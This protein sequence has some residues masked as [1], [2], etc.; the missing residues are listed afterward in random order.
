MGKVLPAAVKS[1][2]LPELVV[3]PVTVVPLAEAAMVPVNTKSAVPRLVAAVPKF[4]IKVEPSA[5][6]PL[7]S[8]YNTVSFEAFVNAKKPAVVELPR[9]LACAS[10]KE[11]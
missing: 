3:V 11:A 6:V 8:K 4:A 1:A 5:A 9:A 10:C 2:M 7:E